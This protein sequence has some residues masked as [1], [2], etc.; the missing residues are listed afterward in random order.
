MCIIPP[1]I[2]T[3]AFSG[4]VGQ[5]SVK[6][7]LGVYLGSYRQTGN[8]PFLNFIAGAGSGKTQFC[9]T[10][11]ENLQKPEG[12]RPPML[13]VNAAGIPDAEAFFEQVWPE[14]KS[15][16]AF[17]FLDEAHNL[18]KSLQEIFLTALNTEE[19]NVRTVTFEDMAYTFNFNRFSIAFGTT[20]QQK[21][22]PPLRDRLKN[23]SFEN[24]KETELMQ[25][26]KRNLHK[27]L[28][29]KKEVVP[30]IISRFRGNPRDAVLKAHDMYDFSRATHQTEVS[31]HFWF[32]FCDAMG[33]LPFGLNHGEL[34]VLRAIGNRA[35]SLT[36][37][38]AITGLSRAA[39]QRDYEPFLMRKGLMEID[40]KR[41]LTPQGI[42]LYRE[43]S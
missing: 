9:R 6:R 16:N 18:P 23:I 27:S 26:F 24:Y 15:N 37:V 34:Q 25:I 11:R 28:F 36:A 35:L 1:M 43:L 41:R 19:S 10:F 7:R 30:E 12:G 39:I 29:I 31:T 20:D 2:N 13:E 8:L 42:K 40:Q 22:S 33:I 4:L 32:D 21:L 38:T 5:E 3:R 17:L 14:W